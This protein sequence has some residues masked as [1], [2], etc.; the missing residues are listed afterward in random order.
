M[1]ASLAIDRGCIV[2]RYKKADHALTAS[3]RVDYGKVKIIKTSQNLTFKAV[4]DDFLGISST[5]KG[6][7][8]LP[9]TL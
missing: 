6:F 8:D 5:P 2:E 7:N 4:S 1:W 3:K 9:I